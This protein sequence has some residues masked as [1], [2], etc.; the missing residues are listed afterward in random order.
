MIDQMLVGPKTG[1]DN[2]IKCLAVTYYQQFED[3][4]VFITTQEEAE[5]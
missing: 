4:K 5:A 1:Y 3:I 2:F